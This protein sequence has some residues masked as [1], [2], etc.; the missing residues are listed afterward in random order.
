MNY[1]ALL[2][3]KYGNPLT[4][5]PAFTSKWIV[6]WDIPSD[7]RNSIPVLP[8]RVQVNKEFQQPLENAFRSLIKKKLHHEIKTFDGLFNIR[9]QVGT[10]TVPSVHAY[11]LAVDIN[12]ALNPF[13]G[14]VTF[15][16]E[17]LQVWRDAGF[18]VGAD[19]P[20]PR[21]DGMHFEYIPGTQTVVQQAII[22]ADQN[23]WPL[24]ILITAIIT[25]VTFA[26]INRQQHGK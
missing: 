23:K 8:A 3:Q 26:L 14:A 13:N 12:A 4:N 22:F 6:W 15:S 25:V 5:P 10:T 2:D 9:P 17:F 1:L 21:V 18:R 11:G 24:I 19:F 7:I 20:P 16:P